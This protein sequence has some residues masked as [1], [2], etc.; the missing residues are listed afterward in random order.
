MRG[1]LFALAGSIGSAAVLLATAAAAQVV[2]LGASNTAGYGVG[3]GSAYPAQ[4]EAMLREKGYAVTVRN[5]G[6]SG[7]TAVG[8]LARLDTGVPAGTRVAV[9]DPG[10]NDI[11]ACTQAWRPQRC[12][13]KAEHDATVPAISRRLRARGIRVLMANIEFRLI[14]LGDWQADRR[15]LTAA[16]HRII[17]A[18]LLPKVTQALG[19]R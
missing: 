8:M 7:D 19:R 4:L 2:A 16:G 5:A 18:R 9:I 10:N 12:A 17:A 6:R 1:G 13:S 11:K 14:P 15:H 3:A